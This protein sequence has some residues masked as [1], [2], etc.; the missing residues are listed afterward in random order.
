MSLRLDA[1]TSRSTGSPIRLADPPGQDVAEVA[2]GHHEA[3]RRPVR[4]DGQVGRDV[5][6]DLRHDPGPVDGVHRATG[7]TS[8]AER[9]VGEQRP[10]PGPGSRRRCPR[11]A[12]LWTLAA[13][14]V[15]IWR[16][17]TSETRPSGY[18]MTMSTWASPAQASMAAEPVSP[19]VAPR[20][21]DPLA[22]LGEHVVEQAAHQLQRDVLEGERRAPEQLEQVQRHVTGLPSGTT[23]H[24]VGVVE[25][26]VGA[27]HDA[28]EVV[29]VDVALDE[30]P[31]DLDRHLVVG[32]AP[33]RVQRGQLRPRARARR[34]PPSAARPASSTS[35]EARAPGAA[36]GGDVLHAGAQPCADDP[37]DRADPSDHVQRRAARAG[38]PARRPPGRRW[39]MKMRRASSPE[40]LLLHRA[41]G[42]A[43]RAEHA[44]HRGQHAGPVAPPRG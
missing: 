42:H 33:E 19:E 14:T 12:T 10:S 13:S 22:A 17:C 43:V 35:R 25:G 18:R 27:G 31:H 21:A 30:G 8:L 5:V 6:D 11:T 23:G 2:G 7:R 40:A 4:R 3:D 32:Q 38:W 26:G 24:T 20:I 34:G 1:T 29:A 36:P 37:E 44:G 15:V 39:V 28:L 16:R 41:D 9:H